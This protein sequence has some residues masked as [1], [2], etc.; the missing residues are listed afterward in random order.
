MEPEVW[1]IVRDTNVV[2]GHGDN[3]D[4]PVLA[5]K[6]YDVKALHPAFLSEKMAQDYIAGQPDNYR[7]RPQK[8]ELQEET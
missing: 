3:A 8:L 2:H 5:Y 7:M 1:V 4:E 6:G